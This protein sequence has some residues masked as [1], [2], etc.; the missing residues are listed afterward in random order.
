MNNK[1]I[2]RQCVFSFIAV[3]SFAGCE[4]ISGT[5]NELYD[6]PRE[7]WG[8][9]V[10]I[11]TGDIW[12][13]GSNWKATNNTVGSGAVI[14]KQSGNVIKITEQ[15]KTDIYLF[16]SRLPNASFSGRVADMDSA[17]SSVHGG[18]A[19]S[20]FNN[21]AITIRNLKDMA[22]TVTTQTNSDGTYTAD[23]I[24][25]GDEYEVTVGGETT[26]VTVNTDG[27]DVG[28]ITIVPDGVNFKTT[29]ERTSTNQDM[30]RLRT[31]T[32][33]QFN[34]VIENTGDADC[35]APRYTLYPEAGI[36]LDQPITGI[37]STIESG[38]TKVIPINV[39][40]SSITGESEYKKIDITIY[41]QL[42]NRTWNDSVSLKFN[43]E[44]VYLNIRSDSNVL[45]GK[46]VSGLIIVPGAKAYSFTT[47]STTGG[48]YGPIPKYYSKDY[49]VVFSGA[50]A[51][52]ETFYSFSISDTTAYAPGLSVFD[53][54]TVGEGGA[55]NDSETTA[56]QIN[57]PYS[58]MAYL[59]KNDIDFYKVNFGPAP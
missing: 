16:A 38:A 31:N 12:R 43:R 21:M 37:L 14:E 19:I 53:D 23:G 28:T 20:G 25:A 1:Q 52:T 2:L 48:S 47:T 9:W 34:I 7:I 57:A 15:G 27:D 5:L 45:P 51:N 24:V 33:Y 42:G 13:F 50:S 18:R 17:A 32:T 22:N 58:V 56:M 35:L 54:T 4:P 10:R 49:L 8:E 46:T 11:D 3:F 36:T 6:Y 44:W 29:L 26:T 59:H 41:S 55:G 40:C 30:M 39:S